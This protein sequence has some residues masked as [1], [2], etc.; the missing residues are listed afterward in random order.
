MNYVIEPNSGYWFSAGKFKAG[1][2]ILFKAGQHDYFSGT[3]CS[4]EPLNPIFVSFEAGVVFSKG[5]DFTNCRHWVIDGGP[6]K[7][8]YIKG[9]NG[10]AMGFKGKCG[11]ITIKGVK[12]EGCYSFIWFKTEVNEQQFANWDYWTKNPDGTI[13]ASYVMDGLTLENFDFQT[14]NFDGGYIGSTGQKADRPVTIDGVTY[15]PFPV[16]VKNIKISNGTLN[17]SSRTGLQISGLI[18]ADSY[19]RGCTISNSGRGREA[20]QGANFRLGFN[21]PD[22]FEISDCIF[23]GS[24]LYNV[25]TQCGG[26]LIFNGNTVKNSCVVN[27]VPNIEK[28]AAVQIDTFNQYP[29]KINVQYNTIDKSNNNVSL[30]IYGTKQSLSPDSIVANNTLQGAVS[31]THL[32]A[33]ETP[34]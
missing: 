32:R 1:D 5:F 33:H 16:N 29:A 21:S 20:Y 8:F 6:D 3:E 19:L 34:E 22:G 4:G 27:G 14:C 18:G 13:S 12:I 2:T 23:D 10:V 30:V 17:D 31:Y 11:N 7:R 15:L 25:Q 28:M 9:A 26:N 24:F